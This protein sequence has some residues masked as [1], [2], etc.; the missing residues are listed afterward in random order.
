[1][2]AV[3]ATLLRQ[4]GR[5]GRVELELVGQSGDSRRH[6]E[7]VAFARYCI[8]RIERELGELGHWRL[9]V[10]PTMGGFST[11]VTVDGGAYRAEIAATGFDGPLAIW[12]A[13]CRIEQMLREAKARRSVP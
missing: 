7:L 6:R 12:D 1:M 3:M 10:T 5:G 2:L 13:M 11:T 9:K 8:T 4:R